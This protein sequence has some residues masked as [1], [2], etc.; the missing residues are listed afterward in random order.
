MLGIILAHPLQKR[1]VTL[2]S[3]LARHRDCGLKRLGNFPFWRSEDPFLESL[4]PVYKQATSHGM[5]LFER[6]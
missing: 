4:E 3:L 1:L 6:D 2:P 5:A